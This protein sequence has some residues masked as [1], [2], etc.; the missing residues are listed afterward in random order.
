MEC[1]CQPRIASQILPLPRQAEVAV[2]EVFAGVQVAAQAGF[3]VAD[4][5]VTLRG[6]SGAEHT[7]AV[8]V[9]D[10]Y[11]NQAVAKVLVR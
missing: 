9:T 6:P 11:D 2:G 1:H 4:R 10:E 5:R 3:Q 7:I 8:R